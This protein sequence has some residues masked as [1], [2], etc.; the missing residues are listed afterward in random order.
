M[1]KTIDQ[2]YNP[3][4]MLRAIELS[5]IAYQSGRGLPIGCVIVKNGKIIGEGHNEIFERINPT[6]HGEMV[7]IER[8]CTNIKNLQLS[9]C[10]MYTT[11]EP[12]PMCLGAIYWAKISKVF[13]SNTNAEASK[14]GFDDTFIFDELR[15]CAHERK[16]NFIHCPDKK[17]MDVLEEWQ[18]KELASAQPWNADK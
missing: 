11:L 15:K 18:S 13:Y 10:Q 16:I 2:D 12:C 6:S 3:K 4:F 1:T 14:V 9:N 5:E 17:A 7:A 8:A